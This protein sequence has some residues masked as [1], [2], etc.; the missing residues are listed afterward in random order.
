[1]V[2]FLGGDGGN[3]PRFAEIH[4]EEKEHTADHG[5]RQDSHHKFSNFQP[6]RGWVLSMCLCLTRGGL[7]KW[8]GLLR[9]AQL[10][11]EQWRGSQNMCFSWHMLFVV[12]VKL[13]MEVLG[14]L[15]LA[16]GMMVGTVVALIDF[17]S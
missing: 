12:W 9:V 11:A 6:V 15:P 10:A 1:M 17:V 7:Q 3:R 5:A 2:L 14:V 16:L 4:C 13:V 8:G